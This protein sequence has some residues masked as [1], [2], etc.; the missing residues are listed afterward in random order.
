MECADNAGACE[1]KG[2]DMDDF[3]E[4][5]RSEADITSVISEYVPLKKK[6]RNYWGCCPF[7]HEKTASFSVTPDK[8]F[9]YCFGCQ[10]GGN[11][12]NFLMRVENIGF[13]D[14]VKLLAGKLHI[15]LPE[16]EK[17][18]KDRLREKEMAKLYSVNELARD[19]FHS[20]L[21]KTAYGKPALEY[22]ASR[23]IEPAVIE[24]YKI[25]FAPQA[26]DKLSSAF[27]E[28]G[29]DAD[30]LQK[31]GLSA[32]RTTGGGLY[33]R[34]RNR[35]MFPI[36]DVRSRVIGFGGR[37]LD[38]SEPKYLN[39]PETPVFNK[40]HVLYGFDHAYR[41][42]REAGKA[43]VVEGYLDL[44]A[45][46]TAG[47]ANVVASLGTA[48]TP[49]QAKLL[50]K[51]A[52]EIIFAYDSDVAGQNATVRALE[53]AKTLGAAVRILSIPD[54]KD[55]DE[56]IR[57]HGAAAFSQ[58]VT[59]A[60]GLVDYR[61]QRLLASIDYSGLE[62]KL[63]IIAQAMPVLASSDNDVEI[64][65]HITRLSDT[66]A[67]DEGAIRS[68]FR[69]YARIHKKDKNVKIG[70]NINIVQMPGRPAQAAVSAERQIIRMLCYDSSIIPYVR[71][72]LSEFD[73]RDP[74]R[75]EIINSL[76]NAYNMKNIVDPA[77]LTT[78]MS[79]AAS[80]ELSHIMLTDSPQG[81][82][83]TK[84]VDDCL[85]TICLTRL[86][87]QYEQQRIKVEELE[88]VGDSR[89]LQELAEMQRI[90]DEINKLHS[91]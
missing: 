12:F 90:K 62:G 41:A 53:T 37:V 10:A 50:L 73:F 66:L 76:F 68:E 69:K 51:H 1:C 71:A 38:N 88:R 79:E 57:K 15:A 75:Q 28:R 39:S 32:A 14:A 56:F 27:A 78:V 65:T 87:E 67:V 34:F 31:S 25:G 48:F 85:R 11:V 19:F 81:G 70:N 20:C 89:C 61:I 36:C 29:I 52:N 17:S 55:P 23:G 9:F 16:K 58:L 91:M 42:I 82:D 30:I 18:E 5:L 3:I 24:R 72:E 4:K 84:I 86:N 49:E 7:H 40:K 13:Y 2:D 63:T 60:L 46:Q 35:I 21:T 77:V 6:G 59:A 80:A 45:A 54:G 33:D 43:V 47:Y 44:I 74:A 26:W 83:I 8:G 22:L 64:N